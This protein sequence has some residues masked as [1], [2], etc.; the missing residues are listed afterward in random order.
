VLG[1]DDLGDLQAAYDHIGAGKAPEVELAGSLA[2]GIFVHESDCVVIGSAEQG[3]KIDVCSQVNLQ[4]AIMDEEIEN[5]GAAL[6]L[7]IAVL[8]SDSPV[9]AF[10]VLTGPNDPT[11][12]EDTQ[13][14]DH[15]VVG[16]HS[17]LVFTVSEQ[18][19]PGGTPTPAPIPAQ[20][21]GKGKSGAIGILVGACNPNEFTQMPAQ[22]LQNKMEVLGEADVYLSSQQE[23]AMA[24][25]D[26]YESVIGQLDIAVEDMVSDF[27]EVASS[28]DVNISGLVC[29]ADFDPDAF[30]KGKT[31]VF[32]IGVA[33]MVSPAAVVAGNVILMADATLNGEV[34]AE[35]LTASSL[36]DAVVA[37]SASA[38]TLAIGILD[39]HCGFWYLT[40]GGLVLVPTTVTSNLVMSATATSDISVEAAQIVAN[41]GGSAE[42]HG[43]GS[44]I[45]TG[46]LVI[47]TDSLIT[48]ASLSS[49]PFSLP[50]DATVTYN[51]VHGVGTS[52]LD[53][54]GYNLVSE[55]LAE[56][57][58]LCIGVGTGITVI[59]QAFPVIKGNGDL[60]HIGS[61][62]QTDPALNGMSFVTGT[63]NATG[64]ADAQG[65]A[66]EDPFVAVGSLGIGVG[67]A[68]VFCIDPQIT[69]NC[70]FHKNVYSG[71]TNPGGGTEA[72]PFNPWTDTFVTGMA[73]A[74][75]VGNAIDNAYLVGAQNTAA[76][77]FT[78][79]AGIGIMIASCDGCFV[80][81]NHAQGGIQGEVPELV[82]ASASVYGL[83][84]D[85]LQHAW[86]EAFA[87]ALADGILLG[88]VIAEF[89]DDGMWHIPFCVKESN[90][91]EAGAEAEISSVSENP[92]PF[93]L[94]AAIDAF[95]LF[96]NQ[97]VHS[98]SIEFISPVIFNYND[99]PGLLLSGANA[100]DL[101]MLVVNLT[102]LPWEQEDDTS[103]LF[104]DARYNYWGDP[105]NPTDYLD[106]STFNLTGPGGIGFGTGQPLYVSATW[107]TA[108]VCY[109][110]WLTINHEWCLDSHIGKFGKVIE[111]GKCWNT[112]SVPI[113]LDDVT[114]GSDPYNTWAG[115]KL[116]NMDI[117]TDNIGP[118][119]Y[120]DAG[121]TPPQ[122]KTLEA[123]HILT[124]LE[125]YKVYV[126]CAA[127][128]LILA[129]T[130]ETM[131]TLPVYKGWNLVGPNPPFCDPGMCVR[132]F[133]SSLVR[134]SGMD[135]FT[136]V[137]S[138]GSSQ[139]N[140]SYTIGDWVSDDNDQF[141]KIGK[142][143]W[144]FMNG[145]QT[146]AG[147][148]FTRLPLYPEHFH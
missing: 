88:N 33:V 134:T 84:Q 28:P 8:E 101:G 21:E 19:V 57:D 67:I 92:D 17:L 66:A 81:D 96:D 113:A 9:V 111:L 12:A 147:F 18:T 68:A 105:L 61:Y 127:A 117:F 41:S 145:N 133:V 53:V 91:F 135:G 144:V 97:E 74:I 46:I 11:G 6:A 87:F 16:V 109:Q 26:W 60:L 59:A 1:K 35:V 89:Q 54:H 129:S 64:S 114:V 39:Y 34:I 83:E 112:F 43:E 121:A 90:T 23:V 131:P 85:P 139:R 124:P 69:D 80:S 45:G 126:K 25:V 10:N 48:A 108:F 148:G 86:T 58:G 136:Q 22:V 4:I 2:I 24:G 55:E 115:F 82:S 103:I 102:N 49:E 137:I 73:T 31:F 120:W 44:A 107:F 27:A 125:G 75:G 72:T 142:A 38:L 78:V 100:A 123:T 36:D 40:P 30:A 14:F 50:S 32:G 122:W 128:A 132:D 13:D 130:A 79:A 20:I 99:M 104:V 56:A 95:I 143:Y 70:N 76:I 71:G 106:N 140:W 47:G 63:G 52:N 77:G 94:A 65:V 116:L 37:N 146:L 3:N 7:G 110:P 51:S 118:A 5:G 138:Q 15:D 141:M 29:A 119:V 62:T 93:V 42:A 98:P